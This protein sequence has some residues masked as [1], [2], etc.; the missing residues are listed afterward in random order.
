MGGEP[1]LEGARSPVVM[2][3]KT[4]F[5]LGV[6][7]GG[8]H[9]ACPPPARPG[10]R[11]PPLHPKTDVLKW[12]VPSEAQQSFPGVLKIPSPMAYITAPTWQARSSPLAGLVGLKGQSLASR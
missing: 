12:M 5:S 4:C 7:P 1:V 9:A 8:S 2:Q 11:S 10:E 3:V 6:L